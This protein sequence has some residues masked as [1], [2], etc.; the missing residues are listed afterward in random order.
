[1]R[2][3]VALS[4]TSADPWV[5]GLQNALAA[6]H[7]YAWKTGDAPA[8]TAVV[9]SPPQ[10][11]FDQHPNL[12]VVFN[13]GAGVDALLKLN[14]LS[15]TSIVRLEDAGMSVQM[16]EYVLNVVVRHFREFDV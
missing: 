7:V 5:N 14:L 10:A 8:D 3:A 4:H 11:F 2:I 9:W 13:T 15:T 16:C 6:H 12:K 1:M